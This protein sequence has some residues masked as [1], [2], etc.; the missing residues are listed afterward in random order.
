M[1]C[2]VCYS[3]LASC[4]CNL[5]YSLE[6]ASPF[7][8]NNVTLETAIRGYF[9][10]GIVAGVSVGLL[11]P[12]T[13]S[14]IGSVIVGIL[15]GTPAMGAIMLTADGPAA[16]ARFDEIFAILVGGILLGGW[17]GFHFWQKS[18]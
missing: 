12:W 11:R 8:A 18:K 6:G 9:A 16:L 3:I 17:G 10:G 5:I 1:G 2:R 4:C 14:R 13:R 15:V 7:T